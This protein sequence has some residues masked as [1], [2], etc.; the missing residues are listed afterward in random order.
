M[1]RNEIHASIGRCS[2]LNQEPSVIG[3]CHL[4]LGW[5]NGWHLQGGK[6]KRH[7]Q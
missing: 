4:G 1:R 7:E 5:E 2:P 6:L 3:A